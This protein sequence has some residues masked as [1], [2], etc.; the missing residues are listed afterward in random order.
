MRVYDP[1]MKY[2]D[3]CGIQT[4]TLTYSEIEKSSTENCPSQLIKEVNGGAIIKT[5]IRKLH[6]G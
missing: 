5:D 6:R 4:V 3:E 1:L 2:L